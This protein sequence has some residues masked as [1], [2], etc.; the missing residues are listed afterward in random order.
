MRA[1]ALRKGILLRLLLRLQLREQLG[2]VER[3]RRRHHYN[4]RRQARPTLLAREH[5]NQK[6]TFPR[7][8][9]SRAASSAVTT[10]RRSGPRACRARATRPS[11]RNHSWTRRRRARAGRDSAF[12]DGTFGSWPRR[13]CV[14]LSHFWHPSFIDWPLVLQPV[15]KA[16]KHREL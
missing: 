12:C 6:I 8:S 15:N 1:H 16:Q 10:R 13:Q 9:G 4:R 14:C 5:V 2:L 7:P 11:S 3:R